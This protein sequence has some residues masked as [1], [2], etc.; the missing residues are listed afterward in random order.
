MLCQTNVQSSS[1]NSTPSSVQ[2]G[3]LGPVLSPSS[4]ANSQNATFSCHAS[5]VDTVSKIV[6]LGTAKVLVKDAYG[7]CQEIRA[8]LDSG[9]QRSIITADCAARLTDVYKRQ[10]QK[11]VNFSNL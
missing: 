7:Q 10:V 2:T 4:C 6:L 8:V 5:T 11:S 3:A 1:V 9:S